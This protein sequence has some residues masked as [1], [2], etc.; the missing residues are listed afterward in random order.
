M[1]A[2]EGGFEP[3]FIGLGAVDGRP[4][5]RDIEG[6]EVEVSPGVALVRGSLIPLE[7][8][9]IIHGHAEPVAIGDAEV[10]HGFHMTLL[11]GLEQPLPGLRLVLRHQPSVLVDHRELELR[12]GVSAAGLLAQEVHGIHDAM[13][14]GDARIRAGEAAKDF[15][16][17][18]AW[19][20]LS[21]LRRKAHAA[22]V[23]P[24]SESQRPASGG[25]RSERTF[26]RSS[27]LVR[28]RPLS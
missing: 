25:L 17:A 2:A 28:A 14:A 18:A 13:S 21:G 9:D 16:D 22:G 1:H 6:S 19:G 12:L 4:A 24:N 15:A 3:V 5:S 7:R 11:G 23:Q 27:A 20:R 10:E 26:S 8:L